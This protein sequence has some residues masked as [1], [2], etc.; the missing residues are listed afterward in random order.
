MGWRTRVLGVVAAVVGVTCFSAMPVLATEP[1]TIV[2][3]PG[4]SIQAA[5]DSAKPG[6]TILVKPG[7]YRENVLI[8]TDRLT[9]RGEGAGKTILAPPEKD[10]QCGICV[11]IPFAPFTK[12]VTGV[13]IS[14]LTVRDFGGFGVFGFGT[15]GLQVSWV[16]AANNAFYG[17]SRF[18]STRTVFRNNRAW[19]SNEAGFY[20]GDAQDAD[21][22]VEDNKAWNNDLGI[23]VR[24]ARH[25][26]I[27]DN[28]VWGNCFGMLVLDDSQAGGAGNVSIHDNKV[29]GNTRVCQQT[30]P[31]GP[32]T[33]GGAG[34]VILGGDHNW[35]SDNN[36]SDNA[37]ETP[38]SG[39]V[40][41]LSSAPFGGHDAM[42]NTVT[43]NELR[44]NHPADIV[45]DGKGTGNTFTDNECTTSLPPGFCHKS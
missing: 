13:H 36:V 1:H 11:G 35:I 27:A 26:N 32:P 7:T 37:A 9:L 39:G 2:V 4:H 18:E 16:D 10:N 30:D 17:I 42:N 6:D 19:G 14:R 31:Q 24:H 34:V 45:W 40:V 41:V 5:V 15:D 12:M 29:H 20:I 23:F 38:F 43:D 3:T 28:E 33:H 21:T 8:T 22:V 25:V 44:N